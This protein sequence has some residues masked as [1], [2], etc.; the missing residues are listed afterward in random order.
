[1]KIKK[2]IEK[3]FFPEAYIYCS[4]FWVPHCLCW[5]QDPSS[6][7]YQLQW[8]TQWANSWAFVCSL[9][10]IWH[11][12]ISRFDIDRLWLLLLGNG[13]C[14]R[15]WYI[16]VYLL[17]VPNWDHLS[18]SVESRLFSVRCKEW[19]SHWNP[20]LAWVFTVVITNPCRDSLWNSST[21][22][23]CKVLWRIVGQIYLVLSR[24]QATFLCSVFLLL[25]VR[26]ILQVL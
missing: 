10:S 9:F 13:N 11:L 23:N 2:N 5:S 24:D 26:L 18:C 16:R 21:E 3:F 14:I 1:M 15:G 4:F 6:F 8:L 19:E 7:P 22:E 12:Y 20:S 17:F 25:I